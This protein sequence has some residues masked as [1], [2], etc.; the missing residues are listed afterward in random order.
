M[1]AGR[2]GPEGDV[3]NS[4]LPCL[5]VEHDVIDAYGGNNIG[6]FQIG[7]MIQPEREIVDMTGS[8]LSGHACI[9]DTGLIALITQ[10][11]AKDIRPCFP[12]GDETL[13]CRASAKGDDTDITGS[14]KVASQ[15]II[16]PAIGDR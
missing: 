14:A 8:G 11:G 3:I 15:A 2:L 5:A 6:R 10:A 13:I 1:G 7:D 4:T 12:F 16:V 9:G